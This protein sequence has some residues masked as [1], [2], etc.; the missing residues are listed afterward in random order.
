MR[1]NNP[2]KVARWLIPIFVLALVAA[3]CGDDEGATT[4]T[5]G[6]SDDGGGS[7]R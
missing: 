5:Q 1:A 4:T 7:G 2:I 6:D 3:S